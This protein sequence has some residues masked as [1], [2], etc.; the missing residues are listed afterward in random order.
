MVRSAAKGQVAT[1]TEQ[2]FKMFGGEVC[3]VVLEFDRS[4][5]GAVY[6]RF[7]EGTKMMA[8][9]ESKCIA[10]VK[11]QVSPVFWGWLFQFAGQMQ[12]LSPSHLIAQYKE[13]CGLITDAK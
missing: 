11:V 3:D 1:Y 9:S 8:T 12:I 5:I 7:G 2:A 13:R 4:L 10:A 6:D